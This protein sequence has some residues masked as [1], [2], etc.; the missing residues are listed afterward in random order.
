MYEPNA[1]L[2]FMM[3][4]LRVA[5][6]LK[7][8]FQSSKIW[9]SAVIVQVFNTSITFF[10]PV[11][12]VAGNDKGAFLWC[13]FVLFLACNLIHRDSD[14]SAQ[15]LQVV[16]G[17]D[18]TVVDVSTIKLDIKLI[19]LETINKY[20]RPSDVG[21]QF[22]FS[23]WEEGSQ[24]LSVYDL[25][26]VRAYWVEEEE[27]NFNI[28]EDDIFS[29]WLV[30]ATEYVILFVGGKLEESVFKNISELHGFVA[31][32]NDEDASVDFVG[33]GSI[34]KLKVPV[35][36]VFSHSWIYV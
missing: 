12:V 8:F 29:E 25:S 3:S 30:T 33:E 27:L 26:K 32:F 35:G 28:L 2:F 11:K 18:N 10:L 13:D 21:N 5:S 6:S 9:F 17:S 4:L 20:V 22:R 16:L 24:H 15:I 36:G 19:Y 31:L 34:S 1:R 23:G 7:T 14:R